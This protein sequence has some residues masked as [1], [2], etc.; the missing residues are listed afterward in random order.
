MV[1]FRDA[2][3]FRETAKVSLLDG[4]VPPNEVL[5][6]VITEIAVTTRAIGISSMKIESRVVLIG[7]L[8][9]GEE[10]FRKSTANCPL[11]PCHEALGLTVDLKFDKRPQDV[12]LVLHLGGAYADR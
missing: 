3:L 8:W 1:L 10:S 9:I 4:C 7:S 2:C 6:S 11:G 5:F 12:T